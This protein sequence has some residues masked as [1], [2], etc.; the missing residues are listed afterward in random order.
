MQ[1]AVGGVVGTCSILWI[2]FFN[3]SK[4]NK[5]KEGDSLWNELSN[6]LT[7]LLFGS[8]N[9]FEII[10]KIVIAYANVKSRNMACFLFAGSFPS[11]RFLAPVNVY[12]YRMHRYFLTYEE[13]TDFIQKANKY[14][15][16][17]I[18]QLSTF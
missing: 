13:R 12:V 9:A 14:F 16:L 8:F 6:V 11:E 4:W 5:N 10:N 1:S 17:Y 15:M 2:F 7:M 3:L 18:D